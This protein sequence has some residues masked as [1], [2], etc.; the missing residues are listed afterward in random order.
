MA[1]VLGSDTDLRDISTL[2]PHSNSFVFCGKGKKRQATNGIFNC[3]LH[4]NI[5]TGPIGKNHRA[6]I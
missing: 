3:S 1:F 6:L 4:V 5:Y 2:R